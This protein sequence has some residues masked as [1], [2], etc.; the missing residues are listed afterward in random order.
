M[1][2]KIFEIQTVC[3]QEL[4]KCDCLQALQDLRVRYLGKSGELTAL[5]KSIKDLAQ[6]ERPAFGN[7]VNE[8]RKLLETLFANKTTAL[9]CSEMQRKLQ[10][11]KVDISLTTMQPRG[12]LQPKQFRMIY[13]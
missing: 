10:Q 4:E 13:M 7:K 8:L 6:E 3:C 9:K 11:E 12:A 2:D 1:A 5:L